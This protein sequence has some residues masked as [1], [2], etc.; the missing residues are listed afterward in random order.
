MNTNAIN[1]GMEEDP[2]T[3]VLVDGGVYAGNGAA[4]PTLHEPADWAAGA[5]SG[6]IRWSQTVW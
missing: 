3:K 6:R 2:L 4:T 1:R 5:S